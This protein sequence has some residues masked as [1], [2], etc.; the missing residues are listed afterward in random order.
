MARNFRTLYDR[1]PEESRRRVEERVQESM[2]ELA[3]DEL[4]VARQ[5]TQESLAKKLRTDQGAVSKLERRTDMY[6][7]TLDKTI[8]AMGGSLEL[9]AVFPSGEAH[10]LRITKPR[11]PRAIRRRRR[12]RSR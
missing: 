11:T 6:L 9:R 10:L 7:S 12:A 4:R 5:I 2:K 8:T 1:L 3:L